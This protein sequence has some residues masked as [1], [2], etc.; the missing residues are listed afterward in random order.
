MCKKRPG[1]KVS[2]RSPDRRIGVFTA[3]FWLH[4]LQPYPTCWGLF[5]SIPN[6]CCSPFCAQCCGVLSRTCG[7]F[8]GLQHFWECG[9]VPVPLPSV[10]QVMGFQGVL[11]LHVSTIGCGELMDDCT[12]KVQDIQQV[13]ARM[14]LVHGN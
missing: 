14:Q 5:L 4:M 3:K 7:C 8:G 6:T 11:Q 12:L 9:G 1:R 10:G 2:F 13:V